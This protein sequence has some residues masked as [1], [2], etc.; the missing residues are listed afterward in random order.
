MINQQENS[1]R[2]A[3]GQGADSLKSAC[4]R[5]SLEAELIYDSVCASRGALQILLSANT[6]SDRGQLG[7]LGRPQRWIPIQD[8]LDKLSSQLDQIYG[9]GG[10]LSDSTTSVR[11]SS[12]TGQFIEVAETALTILRSCSS[13]GRISPSALEMIN[14]A[15][16]KVRHNLDQ[17]A[18]AAST[19][20][21]QEMRRLA[22]Q[23]SAI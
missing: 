5:Q 6:R 18:A 19:I 21:E 2:P 22:G 12:L 15:M 20:R 16:M 9:L 4:T 1:T 17:I 23:V 14:P 8:V 10:Q 11:Q 13:D 3:V 7:F